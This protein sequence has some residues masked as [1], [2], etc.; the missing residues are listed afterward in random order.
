LIIHAD[1]AL[2]HLATM[3]Q[4]FLEQSVLERVLHP[5]D[6]PDLAPLDFCL[7]ADVAQLL[8]G[9]ECPDGEA[10]LR[11]INAILAGIET[12]TLERVFL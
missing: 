4:Q 11:A 7:F 9:Q 2:P 8:A 10:L 6:S 3:T 5:A 12:I 1:K